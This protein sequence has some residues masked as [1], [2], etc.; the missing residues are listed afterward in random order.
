MPIARTETGIGAQVTALAS[1]VHP[2]FMLPPLAASGFGVVLAGSVAPVDPV[3]AVTH[4]V[5]VFF[6][7]YTAHVKD[8]YVDFYIRDED[9]DH[10]MSRVGCRLALAGATAGFVAATALLGARAGL[11]AA[12][13][14]VPTWVLGYLHAPQFDTHPVTA[15][16]GYPVGIGLAIVGG[17]YAQ[18]AALTPTVLGF[19]AVF[20]VVLTGVKVIDDATDYA[21][22]RSIDKRT[23]AVVLG[24]RRA[25]RAAYGLMAVGLASVVVFALVGLFP[26]SAVGAVVAFG[27]VAAVARRAGDDDRLATMLLVR[28]SYLFLAALVVAVQF[29]PL[30]GTRFLPFAGPLGLPDIGVLG[31]YTYLATEVLW[32]T[33]A[34]VLLRYADAF[35]T[36]ARTTLVLYPVAY[37][38]D[39]YTLEVGV[40]AIPL[41]TGVEFLGIPLEEHVF[42]LVVPALVVGVHETLRTL[43]G[44]AGDDST[45]RGG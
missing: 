25:R 27:V 7:V 35:R 39:W 31:P 43:T 32:G 18:T 19:A 4:G 34:L 36:A 17:Y 20:V 22:D 3:V 26:P 28:A 29:R 24:R 14:T 6:A 15:T 40:F 12:L 5:A 11:G 33:V 30:A 45:D 8:G 16:A 10:P 13:L 23:V 1:Q 21:Y 44:P 42:M 38:W 2:V 37:V 9:D 41:R